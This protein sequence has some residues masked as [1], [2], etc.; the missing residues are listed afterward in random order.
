VSAILVLSLSVRPTSLAHNFTINRT[1]KP[2]TYVV[3]RFRPLSSKVT[4][5]GGVNEILRFPRRGPENDR[6][7]DEGSAVGSIDRIQDLT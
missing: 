3:H 4:D 5:N 2:R 1:P 6:V 7:N